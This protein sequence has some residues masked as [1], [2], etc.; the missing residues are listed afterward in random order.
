MALPNSAAM[1]R[2]EVIDG[3]IRRDE[4]NNTSDTTI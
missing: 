1:V 3:S 4:P 2:N